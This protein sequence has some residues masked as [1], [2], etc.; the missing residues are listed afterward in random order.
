[1]NSLK[2]LGKP[3]YRISHILD[4]TDCL[5]VFDNYVCASNFLYTGN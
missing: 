2:K 5:L 4:L 1:M 3:I